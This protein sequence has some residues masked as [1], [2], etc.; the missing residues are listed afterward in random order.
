MKQ[1]T[2]TK[3]TF[4]PSELR[5]A[6]PKTHEQ[7][8]DIVYDEAMGSRDLEKL[9]EKVVLCKELDREDLERIQKFARERSFY[10]D[11]D[12]AEEVRQEIEEV[13]N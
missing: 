10:L 11:S 9:A 13:L 3:S 4:E 1:T 6:L 5:N 8:K 12:E 2:Q 7:A